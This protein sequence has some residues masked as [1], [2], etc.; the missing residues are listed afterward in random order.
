MKRIA[1]LVALVMSYGLLATSAQAKQD[2][3]GKKVDQSP[4]AV[5]SYWTSERMRDAK[6]AE[7]KRIAF[8]K[9]GKSTAGAATEVPAPYTTQPT[10][11]NGKVFFTDDGV[12]YVCSGTAIAGA[13]GSVVWT[14]GHCVNDGPGAYHSNWAFVPAYR[15]GAR[16]Y[17]TWAATTLYTTTAWKGS[18]DFGYDLGAA[19]VTQSGTADTLVTRIG[20]GRTLAFNGPRSQTYNAFGYPAAKPFNGQR[21]WKCTSG[22]YLEDT[23]TSPATMG[24]QCNMTGGSSGGA[25]VGADSRVYSVNSYGYANLRNVMFGPYQGDAAQ[26]LYTAADSGAPAQ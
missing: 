15:D 23:T 7:R 21:L 14:A 11:T 17:G 8:A 12:N 1:A 24:I 19:R 10:A 4:A 22:L 13:S 3:D 5:E 26:S 9:G 2:V 18:G 6:P 25:W 16:P 20:G